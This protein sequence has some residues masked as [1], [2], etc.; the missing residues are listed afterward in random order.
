MLRRITPSN[1]LF[2]PLEKIMAPPLVI[3]TRHSPVTSHHSALTTVTS[4]QLVG[5]S[6]RPTTADQWR[7]FEIGR[8]ELNELGRCPAVMAERLANDVVNVEIL[9]FEAVTAH[10]TPK[11]IQIDTLVSDHC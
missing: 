3:I 2:C 9:H 4:H 8:G 11:S 7:T 6:A 5:D 10:G 1:V